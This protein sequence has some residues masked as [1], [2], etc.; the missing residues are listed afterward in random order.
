MKKRILLICLALLPMM[1]N[2]SVK[3]DG[4]NYDLDE[5]KKEATVSNNGN[6]YSGNIVIP[7]SIIYDEMTYSVTSIGNYAFEDCTRLTSI[8]IPNNVTS[9]GYSAF[10]DCI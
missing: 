4:I 9:I 7:S 2:A 10:Y 3:I 8:T 1:V 5:S 6:D